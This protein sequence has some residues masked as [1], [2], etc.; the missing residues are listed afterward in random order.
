MIPIPQYPLYTASITL[1]GGQAV[2]YFLEEEADWGTS[3]QGLEESLA[4]A[5]SQGMDVRALCVIN[6]GNPTGQCLTK[7]NIVEV[8]YMPRELEAIGIKI[9]HPLFK[10]NNRRSFNFVKKRSL[11]F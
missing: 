4:S 11:S 9:T 8:I 10:M 5:R 2:P 6:P 7:D 3:L 1:Y